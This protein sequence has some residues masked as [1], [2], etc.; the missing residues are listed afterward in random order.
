MSITVHLFPELVNQILEYLDT[1]T[2]VQLLRHKYPVKVLKEILEDKP[3]NHLLKCIRLLRPDYW[4]N[5]ENLSNNQVLM[6]ANKKEFENTNEKYKRGLSTYTG[7]KKNRHGSYNYAR[8]KQI[9]I[10]NWR[11][12]WAVYFRQADYSL[13]LKDEII[14]NIRR[15]KKQ[16]KKGEMDDT[17]EKNVLEFYKQ[18]LM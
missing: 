9:R 1:H 4:M 6:A 15:L 18:I 3:A 5:D 10:E 14:E 11:D 2:R 13:R 12:K 17:S 8:E 16:Y 7:K